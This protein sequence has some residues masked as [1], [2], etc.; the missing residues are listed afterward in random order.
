[1]GTTAMPVEADFVSMNR[2][3]RAV[4]ACGARSVDAC[5]SKACIYLGI[6][7]GLA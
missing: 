2:L 6:R 4:Q 1:M 3:L 5:I 7:N